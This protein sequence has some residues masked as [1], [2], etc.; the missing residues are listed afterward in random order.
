MKYLKKFKLFESIQ[1]EVTIDGYKY[2]IQPLKINL[3]EF[4]DDGT[5]PK[6][7]KKSYVV[8]NED[9]KPYVGILSHINDDNNER[10]S[11][12]PY[13]YSKDLGYISAILKH[14]LECGIQDLYEIISTDN[15]DGKVYYKH[16]DGSASDWNPEW[17]F[18]FDNGIFIHNDL[19]NKFKE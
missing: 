10:Q 1:N 6:Y 12:D 3:K 11:F 16:L 5:S 13:N 4:D 7:C 2:I 18:G 15:K 9:G 19:K 14:G 17:T 8:I